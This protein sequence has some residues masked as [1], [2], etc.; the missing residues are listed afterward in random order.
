[1]RISQ[2]RCLHAAL[3]YAARGWPVFPVLERGKTPATAHGFHDATVQPGRI[4]Q[5]WNTIH[6]YN[7]GIATGAASGVWMLDVDGD[8]GATTLGW[9]EAKHGRLPST[10]TCITSSG[11][12][13]WFRTEDPVPSRANII[14]DDNLGHPCGLD[15]RGDGGYAIVP[16]SIH[17][18]GSVYRWSGP[19]EPAQAPKW[20]VDRTRKQEP[21]VTGAVARIGGR[22]ATAYGKAALD[23]EAE[24]LGNT[25]PGERNAVLFKASAN[26]FQ[27][28]AGGALNAGQVYLRLVEACIA[29]GL[30]AD[31]GR[32]S[33]DKTIASG[34]RTG[35]R[36]PRR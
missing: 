19:D 36:S 12:H 1:M 27:L 6:N 4:R 18:D 10:M 32:L 16:P 31:D 13:L 23:Y 29:N 30:I 35:F 22:D 15:V 26:L 17:P 24:S 11:C 9:L 8:R 20:L 34:A 3:I 5:W 7:I 33:V 28:V 25:G 21:R 2:N 14:G